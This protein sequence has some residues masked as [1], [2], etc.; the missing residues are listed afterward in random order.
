MHDDTY[1]WRI[2]LT[3]GSE[4]S[5]GA[6]SRL[7]RDLD[8]AILAAIERVMSESAEGADAIEIAAGAGDGVERR[9][10]F[11]KAY[12]VAEIPSA[13]DDETYLT[14]ADAIEQMRSFAKFAVQ[15]DDCLTII[16]EGNGS[17]R[18]GKHKRDGCDFETLT[19]AEQAL[20]EFADST[21]FA[22]IPY[23]EVTSESEIDG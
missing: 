15:R 22:V 11:K 7:A 9:V 18:I 19:D 23:L 13:V 12:Q 8:A 3:F 5:F 16:R 10:T 4:S 21:R 17:Y 6:M 1:N 20:R 14:A 2:G